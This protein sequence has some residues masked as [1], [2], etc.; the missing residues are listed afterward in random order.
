MVYVAVAGWV[1]LL[2]LSFSAGTGI[3]FGMIPAFKDALLYSIDVLRT[4]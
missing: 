1:V 4:E 3:L 2:A